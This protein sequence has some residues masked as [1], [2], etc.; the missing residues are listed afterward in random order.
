VRTLFLLS[1]LF[2][3]SADAATLRVQAVFPAQGNDASCSQPA[4]LSPAPAGVTATRIHYQ[5]IGPLNGE[6]SVATAIGQLGPMAKTVPLGAYRVIG[7]AS[8]VTADAVYAAGCPDTVTKV[9]WGAPARI[10]MGRNATP[11]LLPEFLRETPL[12]V[13]PSGRPGAG[14]AGRASPL[15]L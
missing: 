1:L 4:V 12:A 13:R 11:L 6:D 2:A 5:W 3:G 14:T 7:W 10:I 9:L 15:P 8:W